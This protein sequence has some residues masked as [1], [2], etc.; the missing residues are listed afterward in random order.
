[1]LPN[2]YIQRIY[3]NYTLYLKDS[4]AQQSDA[5]EEMVEE[6]EGSGGSGGN[7]AEAPTKTTTN[8][9]NNNLDIRSQQI[10]SIREMYSTMDNINVEGIEEY[11]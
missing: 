2:R 8:T 6:L 9:A 10:K 11:E 5:V 1:M 3:K 4:K 7:T